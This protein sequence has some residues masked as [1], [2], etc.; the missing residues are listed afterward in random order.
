MQLPKLTS[1]LSWPQTTIVLLIASVGAMATALVAQY[2]FGHTPCI[3]C[4]WQRYPLG[5]I[6]FLSALALIIRSTKHRQILFLSLIT[7]A[8][9]IAAGIA[10]FHTGVEQHWW[11]GT[12]GCAI[13]NGPVG[14]AA[15]IRAQ[16][17]ATEIARCDEI[18][19]SFLGFSMA[20]WNI[21]FSLFLAILA[22]A[23]AA[24]LYRGR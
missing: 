6:I 17:L 18:S 8:A 9:L 19:W 14:D 2:I 3:L 16:L 23:S 15:S 21:L 24:R 13:Q 20:N 11:G 5:V 22:G 12:A 7:F 1:F 4:I 10:F